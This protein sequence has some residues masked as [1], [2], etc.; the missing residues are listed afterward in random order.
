MQTDKEVGQFA[1]EAEKRLG[2][3]AHTNNRENNAD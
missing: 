1:T 2:Q 3:S